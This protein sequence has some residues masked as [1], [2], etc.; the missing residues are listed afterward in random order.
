MIRG[1]FI[2]G[3][4]TACGK[5]YVARALITALQRRGLRVAGF[6]PVAA[7]AERGDGF[8]Q[9]DDALSLSA[10]SNLDIP[11]D[12]INP[13]CFEAAVAPHI[14]AA[15]GG[16]QIEL[17]KILAAREAIARRAD[18]IVAEGAGGWRVPLAADLDMQGL[19]VAL[20]MPV[21]L[22]VGLRLGCLNHALLTEQAILASGT[23]LLGWVGTQVDLQMARVSDNLA[24]LLERL[25]VPC[26][27]V[28]SHARAAAGIEI[29]R[30]LALDMLLN[31]SADAAS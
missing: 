25:S 3:T 20:G 22:V 24:T 13:Y 14:A 28:L 16:L 27:G 29:S 12:V 18:Y 19:A 30:A 6:K 9:N 10:A 11:Y 2:T 8:L 26:L 4:D 7:G 1:V 17:S 15:D 31:G 21:L 5:T 23:P